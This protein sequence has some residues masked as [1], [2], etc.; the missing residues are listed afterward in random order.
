MTVFICCE[1]F[2]SCQDLLVV[3]GVENL[4]KNRNFGKK[5]SKVLRKSLFWFKNIKFLVK[6]SQFWKK[7]KF[8]IIIKFSVKNLNFGLKNIFGKN[9]NFI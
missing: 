6:N 8:L 7:S 2:V 4:A 9:R 1:E 5:K 3:S